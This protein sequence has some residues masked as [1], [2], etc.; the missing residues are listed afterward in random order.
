MT[1]N[2]LGSS[3]KMYIYYYDGSTNATPSK[4]VAPSLQASFVQPYIWSGDDPVTTQE[5]T[6]GDYGDIVDDMVEHGVSAIGGSTVVGAG[7]VGDFGQGDLS[8]KASLTTVDRKS[9]V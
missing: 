9:V 2:E 8:G 7:V 5:F 4:D 3:Q 1:G 6:V